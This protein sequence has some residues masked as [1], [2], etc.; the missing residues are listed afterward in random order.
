[1]WFSEGI[2]DR[3]FSRPKN[4]FRVVSENEEVRLSLSF[5]IERLQSDR[6][7]RNFNG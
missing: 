6:V 1:M 7:T 4:Q 3:L 2:V 5:I